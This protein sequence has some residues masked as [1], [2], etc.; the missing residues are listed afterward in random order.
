MFKFFL[1]NLIALIDA[2][3]MLFQ[4]IGILVFSLILLIIVLIVIV[5]FFITLFS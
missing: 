1:S 2:L 5:C 4:S 3:F